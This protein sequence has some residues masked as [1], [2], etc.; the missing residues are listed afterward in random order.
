L[1]VTA[2]ALYGA[3]FPAWSCYS[4][5]ILIPTTDVTGAYTWAIDVQYQ[6]YSRAFRTDALIL[7]TEIGIGDRVEVGFDADITSQVE[8]ERR[9]LL[10]GKVV[11]FRSEEKG[12]ALAAGFTNYHSRFAP[13]AYVVGSKDFGVLRAHAGVQYDRDA[14]R[15]DGFVGL[16]RT[17]ESGWAVMA[18]YTGGEENYSSVGFGKQFTERFG[19]FLGA[20]WPN[21]GGPGVYVVH[22]VIAGPVKKR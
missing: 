3:A 15:W 6:G 7:N 20:Q 5:L 17:F 14:H 16:D 13:I 8:V 19:L 9:F 4:G 11:L 22:V 21:G 10:N 1:A 18:D 2:L 12:F